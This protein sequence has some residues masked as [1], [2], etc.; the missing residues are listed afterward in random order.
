MSQSPLL[1]C[2][3]GRRGRP[4]R[5]RDPVHGRHRDRDGDGV[6]CE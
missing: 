5:R 2:R 4:I 6:A 3:P 1:Q